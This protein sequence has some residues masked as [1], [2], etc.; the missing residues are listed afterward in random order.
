MNS[1]AHAD[2]ASDE[3]ESTGRVFR[4]ARDIADAL[5]ESRR[6]VPQR[7]DSAHAAGDK[8]PS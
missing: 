8:K 5:V 7:P 6:R 4:S 2:A 3:V 1:P